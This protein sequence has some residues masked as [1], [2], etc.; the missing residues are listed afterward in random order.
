[1]LTSFKITMISSI[2]YYFYFRKKT[3]L[4]D[5]HYI[6]IVKGQMH[7]NNICITYSF[8]K[9]L[10]NSRLINKTLNVRFTID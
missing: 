6:Y 5:R 8:L 4:D 9:L 3:Q 10:F 1:M 7:D 2:K